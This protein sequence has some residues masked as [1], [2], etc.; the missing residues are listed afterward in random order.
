MRKDFSASLVLRSAFQQI[1][2]NKILRGREVTLLMSCSQ[3]LKKLY[4]RLS[5][6]GTERIVIG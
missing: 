6:M 2:D 4:S 3:T 1:S 5:L